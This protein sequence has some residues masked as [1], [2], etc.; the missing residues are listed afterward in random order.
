[1]TLKAGHF[2]VVEGLE[3][4]G[5]STA[6]N[7]IKRFLAERVPELIT[8]REP[9]GTRVGEAA[10]QLIKETVALEPLDARTELLLL[11]ASRVQL[12]EQVIRPALHR[13]C[14]V[15]GDRFELSTWAYQGGGRQLDLDMI[16][17]LSA[18]CVKDIKPDLIIF[19]DISPEQGL[20]RALKRG[21]ADRIE[22]ESLD[23]F[24]NVYNSYHHY[25]KSMPNVVI[26]DA[27]KP[28][29]VVQNLICSALENYVADHV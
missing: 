5:K 28:L 24:T 9:G 23:F 11:Y 25:I 18:F 16:A 6:L 14:W 1:M 13:G 10:R 2:I 15:V 29:A 3:G 19:L 26:I 7:T 12:L 27:N 8:T 20:R 21:K 4:A 17:R 22:Q